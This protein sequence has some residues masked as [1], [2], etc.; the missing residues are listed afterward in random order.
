M[1]TKKPIHYSPAGW[2]KTFVIPA[3]VTYRPAGNLPKEKTDPFYWV[4]GWRGMDAETKAFQKTVGF[5]L[6][7]S[8]IKGESE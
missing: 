3:G 7:K 6:R 8:Q 5:L 4:G 1:K 2:G